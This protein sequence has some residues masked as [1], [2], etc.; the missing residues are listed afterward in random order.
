M[1]SSNTM[2]PRSERASDDEA[3]ISCTDEGAGN[4]PAETQ[5]DPRSFSSILWRELSP[6]LYVSQCQ[7]YELYGSWINGHFAWRGR[8][9]ETDLLIAS[10]QDKGLVEQRC[11]SY[12]RAVIAEATA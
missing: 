6:T 8:V 1:G 12:A 9:I 11:E 5:R 2:V 10:S 3:G 7:Q 4:I